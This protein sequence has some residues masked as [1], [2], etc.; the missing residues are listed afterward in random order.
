MA[1]SER[2]L[3]SSEMEVGSGTASEWTPRITSV[4]ADSTVA[5]LWA[6]PMPTRTQLLFRASTARALQ[7]RTIPLA[8][9]V[10]IAYPLCSPPTHQPPPKR[11]PW[12]LP[13]NLPLCSHRPASTRTTQPTH[14]CARLRAPS[15]PRVVAEG[16]GISASGSASPTHEAVQSSSAEGEK[17]NNAS[18]RVGY[19]RMEASRLG[20]VRRS[21]PCASRHVF[22]MQ[23]NKIRKTHGWPARE[24]VADFLLSCKY[25]SLRVRGP[26][27][28]R[29]SP[30][31]WKK[32]MQRDAWKNRYNLFH[33]RI[34]LVDRVRKG[35]PRIPVLLRQRVRTMISL[36][37]CCL[38]VRRMHVSTR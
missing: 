16:L 8:R 34:R 19:P 1:S 12:S 10:R 38:D 11:S 31:V 7:E 14:S 36:L 5:L 28:I 22:R 35:R 17:T 26:L 15:L 25:F 2:R 27:L 13:D 20:C 37:D 32:P 30:P 6:S 33:T 4:S 9:E 18:A 21:F 24:R 3:S 29:L 23:T